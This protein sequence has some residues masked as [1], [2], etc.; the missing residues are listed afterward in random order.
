[1]FKKIILTIALLASSLSASER[2][3]IDCDEMDCSKHDTFFIHKGNNMWV[4]T[5]TVYRDQTGTYTFEANISRGKHDKQMVDQY[6]KCPYCYS[7]WPR[8]TPCKNPD[9]PSR[10]P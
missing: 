1:M 4:Q 6:W 3:Y 10:Y 7:Y 9:C 2:I 8:G 5:D